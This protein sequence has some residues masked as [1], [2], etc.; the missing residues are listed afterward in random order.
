MSDNTVLGLI[1]ALISLQLMSK[2]RY[3]EKFDTEL[4]EHLEK[5][6]ELGDVLVAFLTGPGRIKWVL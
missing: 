1:I 5:K 2:H 3:H 4:L 6:M